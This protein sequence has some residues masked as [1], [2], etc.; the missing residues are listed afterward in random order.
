[1]NVVDLKDYI[2]GVAR[3]GGNIGLTISMV[4]KVLLFVFW[5]K[6]L[7]TLIIA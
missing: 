2:L 5:L 1:M 7:G 6:P 3:E 4:L